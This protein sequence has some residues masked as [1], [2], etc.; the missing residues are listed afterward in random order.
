MHQCW[1]HLLFLHWQ[2]PA[3]LLQQTL[4]AG[5][6]VDTFAGRAY[7]GIIPFFM[8]KIRPAYLPPLPWLSW[9]LELN[10]RTYVHD[11]HGVPGVWFYSLNANQPV[12]VALARTLF[13]LPYFNAHMRAAVGDW[14]HYQS[15]RRNTPG[16]A[17]YRYRGLGES[18][19]AAVDS[20]EF[21]LLERYFLYAEKNGFLYR[22]Q[23]GHAPYLFQEVEAPF[24]STMPAE[25]DGFSGLAPKPF[26]QCYSRKVDVHILGL[27][28]V[29]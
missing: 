21:F 23:V 24:I 14:I 18:K 25:Q 22:G 10:V 27:E 16:I 13:H 15:T 1:E 26:H 12:A 4:P 7:L 11:R 19:E 2:Y 3:D 20:L 17:T 29:K 28:K 8:Q 9:F 5:L 6:F